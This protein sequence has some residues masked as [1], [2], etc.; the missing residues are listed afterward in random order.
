MRTLEE[1]LILQDQP[2][3]PKAWQMLE[4]LLQGRSRPRHGYESQACLFHGLVAR[5]VREV[6]DATLVE[7]EPL[8]FV[9][10]D[11]PGEH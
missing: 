11:P 1:E 9:D 10:G 6:Y 8:A 2:E 7:G 4:A 5:L 3:L